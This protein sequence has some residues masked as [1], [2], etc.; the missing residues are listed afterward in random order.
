MLEAHRVLGEQEWRDRADAIGTSLADLARE[1]PDGASRWCENPYTPTPDLMIG[2]AGV[3]HL[4]A[5]PATRR[6]PFSP[7]LLPEPRL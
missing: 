4:L 5:R 6:G 2:C 7:P 3:V 1:A